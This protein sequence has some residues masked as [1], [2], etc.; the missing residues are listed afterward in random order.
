MTTDTPHQT[1]ALASILA[2]LLLIIA[3]M[4]VNTTRPKAEIA[5]RTI[6]IQPSRITLAQFMKLEDGMSYQA[7]CRLLGKD[8]T[9]LSRS[10]LSGTS[11]VMY[12]WQNNDLS[13][14][15]AMFQNGQLISKA[16]FGLK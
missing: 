6:Q 14:M 12:Q 5:P 10:N 2:V 11:T 16:Q 1:I 9:E 15:N 8:G 13:N 7:V 4:L 3:G